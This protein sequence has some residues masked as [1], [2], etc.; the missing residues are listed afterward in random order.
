MRVQGFLA[1]LG[2]TRSYVMVNAFLYT[3]TRK[4]RKR[5]VSNR[6]IA[7]YRNAWLDAVFAASP[8]AIAAVVTFGALAKTAWTRWSATQPAAATG[9]LRRG[10]PDAPDRPRGPGRERSGQVPERPHQA[11]AGAVERRARHAPARDPRPGHRDDTNRALRQRLG[12]GGPGRDPRARSARR[13]AGLDAQQHHRVGPAECR[14]VW[15]SRS[16]HPA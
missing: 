11:D 2:V 8:R 12:A 15:A 3:V 9:A 10:A 16:R 4:L 5:V 6:G 7:T 13:T 1:K 14:A